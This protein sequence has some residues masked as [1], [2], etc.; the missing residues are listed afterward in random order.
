MSPTFIIIAIFFND[1]IVAPIRCATKLFE[2]TLTE[3]TWEQLIG[4]RST[5]DPTSL[6][7]LPDQ[8]QLP[9]S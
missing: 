3:L 6:V 5:V 2:S 4:V 8:S 9:I 7:E 1:N